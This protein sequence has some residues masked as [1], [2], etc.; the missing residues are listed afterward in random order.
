MRVPVREVT[1]HARAG[2]GTQS[3][4]QRVAA[5]ASEGVAAQAPQAP[6]APEGAGS[7]G[8]VCGGN[9]GSGVSTC[10]PGP[11]T[12]WLPKLAGATSAIGGVPG[13][14]GHLPTHLHPPSPEASTGQPDR[15]D[16]QGHL[17]VK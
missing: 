9:E 6:Q 7:A 12:P 14:W 16:P 4:T 5:Q 10:A 2:G 11:P 3:L 13:S 1:A 8:R 17:P 15:T